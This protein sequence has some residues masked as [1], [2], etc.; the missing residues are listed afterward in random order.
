MYFQQLNYFDHPQKFGIFFVGLGW[1]WVVSNGFAAWKMTQARFWNSLCRPDAPIIATGILDLIWIETI[2]VRLTWVPPSFRL[3]DGIRL[4]WRRY[5]PR[6]TSLGGLAL[7]QEIDKLGL[8]GLCRST[9]EYTAA[10]NFYC[11]ARDDTKLSGVVDT[12]TYIR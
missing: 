2:T 1:F 8:L 9:F 12:I 7:P 5:A 11:G 10:D 4:M 3:L 6:R